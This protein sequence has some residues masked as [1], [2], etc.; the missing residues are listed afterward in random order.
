MCQPSRELGFSALAYPQGLLE[1]RDCS[2]LPAIAHL[3]LAKMRHEHRCAALAFSSVYLA[4]YKHEEK[5][6]NYQC[7]KKSRQEAKPHFAKLLCIIN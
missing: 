3:I 1:P 5:T 4:G 6:E 7:W 2:Q